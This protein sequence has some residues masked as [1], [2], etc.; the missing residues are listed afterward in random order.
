M[1]RD[2][3]AVWVYTVVRDADPVP[4]ISG[5]SGEPTRWVG[6]C[7]LAAVVGSVPLP[8]F[9]AEAL[10]RNLNDLDRLAAIARDHN[11]VIETVAA[12]R[13]AL[14]V[15][16]AVLCRDDDGVRALLTERNSDLDAAL[17]LV[18]GRAEWG[19]KAFL[20]RPP[21]QEQ[22]SRPAS[23][24]DYLR[25]RRDALRRDH[26]DRAAAERAAAE[27]FQGLSPYTVGARRRTLT[28]NSLT[29]RDTPMLLNAAYL[30]DNAKV[31]EFRAAVTRFADHPDLIV[32]QTGPW[33][34]YS[35]VGALGDPR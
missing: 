27:L 15:R 17:T 30:V 26:I 7:G 1:V 34:P 3:V 22:R 16:L 29:G 21:S 12:S 25:R 28:D 13:P 6:A 33:P 24:A 18:D 8:E 2:T 20:R 4:A 5:V 11:A 35:F 14:P 23:G 19:V 31:T 32:E 9:G 10:Q